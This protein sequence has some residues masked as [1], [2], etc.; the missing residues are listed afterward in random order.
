MTAFLTLDSLS[1]TKPDGSSLFSD[2]TLSLGTE[3]IGIVGRN[4]AGKS[5]LF[6]IIL[7]EIEP[8]RGSVSL[9]GRAGKLE[10]TPEASGSLSK[11]L[12]VEASLAVLD[13]IEAGDASEDDFERADWT[14]PDRIERT[15]AEVGLQAFDLQK[16]VTSLSGGERTRAGLARLFLEQPDILLLDEPTNNLDTDGRRD[17]AALLSGWKGGALIASHDRDLLEAMDRIIHLSP[18]GVTMVTGGWSDFVAAREAELERVQGELDRSSRAL[19]ETRKGIRKQEEKAARRAQTGKLARA[20][21]SQSKLLLN[22]Q[23]ERSE[24]TQGRDASLKQ[25]QL[26]EADNAVSAARARIEI[27]TPLTISLPEVNVPPGRRLLSLDNVGLKLGERALFD[28]VTAEIEGPSRWVIRG[29]NGS[30]KT[31]LLKLTLGEIQPTSG[32]VQHHGHPIAFMDQHVSTLT[33]GMD[34]L[35]NLTTANPGLTEHEAHAVLARFAF[36]NTD[37]HRLPETL[38]GGERMRAGL[39][40]IMSAAEPPQLLILDEPTNHLDIDSLETLEAAL[41]DFTGALLVVSHDERFLQ[42]IGITH[43]IRLGQG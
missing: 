28:G 41:A 7:G 23:K 39:A 4:G 11:L 40:Q 31:S 13:R 42:D 38:S 18:V 32:E 37:A 15:L 33:P 34:L 14:L 27:L 16:T 30:G 12:G 2:L 43:E 35:T 22:A 17:I 3:R 9:N 24:G 10:Q 8:A 21:R 19:A 29:H 36:R 20:S 1:A 25:R 5:T 26:A 6:R